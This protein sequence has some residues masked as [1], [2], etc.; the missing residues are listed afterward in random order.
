MVLE[1]KSEKACLAAQK[2]LIFAEDSLQEIDKNVAR[3]DYSLRHLSVL[4]QESY[5]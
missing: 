2:H 4:G 3:E 5:K 1:G